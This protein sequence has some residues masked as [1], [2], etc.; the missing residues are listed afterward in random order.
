MSYMTTSSATP[1]LSRLLSEWRTWQHS[2]NLSP[3]TVEERCRVIAH[4]Y[5]TSGATLLEITAKDI[6]RFTSRPEISNSSRAAYHTHIRAWCRWLA[7]TGHR[8]DDPSLDTPTPKPPKCRPRPIADDQLPALIAAATRRRT[9]MMVLL[10]ALAG[11]RVHEIAK[12]RGQD[13]DHAAG[14][15]YVSGKGDK[16][17]TVPLHPMILAYAEFFPVKGYWFP[18]YTNPAAPILRNSVS[19]AISDTME[20]AGING[21]PHQLRHWYAT[22]LLAGGADLRTVQELMRHESL[23]STAIYTQ[24]SAASKMAAIAGLTFTAA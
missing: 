21:T 22:R 6:M 3:R 20:R 7:K 24:V 16:T 4:L 2:Q 15:L 11:L 1:G 5:G 18:S 9:K 8:L 17:A 12:V 13:I 10:A 14:L 23:M 19:K